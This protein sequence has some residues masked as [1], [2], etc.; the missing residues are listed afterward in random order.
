MRPRLSVGQLGIVVGV[1]AMACGALFAAHSDWTWLPFAAYPLVLLTRRGRP[2]ARWC[3]VVLALAVV[4]LS[5][6]G[7]RDFVDFM[8]V[9]V[10]SLFILLISPLL[11]WR[12]NWRRDGRVHR[13]ALLVAAGCVAL[14]VSIVATKWPLRATFLASRSDFNAF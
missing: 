14:M 3:P 4:A 5:A 9:G 7:I 11:A 1:A 10:A 8:V 6:G 13:I 2:L 12:R